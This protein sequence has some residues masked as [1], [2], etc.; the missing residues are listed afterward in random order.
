M[1]KTLADVAL[2][3]GFIAAFAG[4]ALWA[5]FIWSFDWGPLWSRG[6]G[7]WGMVLM[8]GAI[9]VFLIVFSIFAWLSDLLD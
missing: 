5:Y 2:V 1:R 4:A 9:L 8:F 6:F 3:S 7:L